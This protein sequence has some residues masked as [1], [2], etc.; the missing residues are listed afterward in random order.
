MAPEV[1]IPKEGAV[2]GLTA[3][4]A[5]LDGKVVAVVVAGHELDWV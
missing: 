2:A 3:E 4:A 5:F 1:F